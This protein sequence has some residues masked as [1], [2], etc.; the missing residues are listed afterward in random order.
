MQLVFILQTKS[1]IL[2][3]VQKAPCNSLEVN[4]VSVSQGTHEHALSTRSLCSHC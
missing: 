4:P 1:E 2:P 3:S